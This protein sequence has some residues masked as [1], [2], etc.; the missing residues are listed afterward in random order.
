ME[1]LNCKLLW[2]LKVLTSIRVLFLLK[3]QL[4]RAKQFII[5]IAENSKKGYS[6][7]KELLFG[8]MTIQTK[9]Y[10]LKVNWQMEI[11]KVEKEHITL[12]IKRI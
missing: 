1:K 6:M 8:V 3:V 10:H 7:G 9:K 12:T 4:C 5:A 2:K 11:L